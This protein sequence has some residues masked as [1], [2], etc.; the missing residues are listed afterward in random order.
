MGIVIP[1][2]SALGQIQRVQAIEM[3]AGAR[4]QVIQSPLVE[5][6]SSFQGRLMASSVNMLFHGPLAGILHYHA[7]RP[8][9]LMEAVRCALKDCTDVRPLVVDVHANYTTHMIWLAEEMPHVDFLELDL[10]HV[11]EQK[12]HRLHQ[13]NLPANLR[14]QGI[15]LSEKK[16]NDALEGRPVSVILAMGSQITHSDY[17]SL[18][19]YLSGFLAENGKIVAGFPT[20]RGIQ[21]LKRNFHVLDRFV[22]NLPGMVESEQQVV[23]LFNQSEYE[24]VTFCRLAQ[25]ASRLKKPTPSEVEIIAVARPRRQQKL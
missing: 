16:L 5:A 22:G 21:N 23:D 10:P 18:L 11:I 15:D 19:R 14:M 13:F 17:A 2:E 3:F 1:G 7:V 20:S 24:L 12:R 6:L 9:C 4:A 25:V 8:Y